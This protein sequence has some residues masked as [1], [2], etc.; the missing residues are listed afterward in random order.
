MTEHR[1]VDDF[2]MTE[3]ISWPEFISFSL[4]DARIR[5]D[6]IRLVNKHVNGFPHRSRGAGAKLAH[7]WDLARGKITREQIEEDRW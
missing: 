1:R 7:L 5:L 4:S 3:E 6:D 2:P